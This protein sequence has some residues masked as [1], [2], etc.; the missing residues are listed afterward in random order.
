MSTSK[1]TLIYDQECPV[2]NNYVQMVRIR[3]SIGELELINARDG[4]EL[5]EEITAKGI[6]LDQGMV[7]IVDDVMYCNSDTIHALA[8]ISSPSGFLNKCNF[9]IF[10]NKRRSYV[11]YPVLRFF[12]RVLLMLLGKKKLNNLEHS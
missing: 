5:V 12:R 8:L 6:D 11:I 2:C 9:W 1:L 4:G 3:E 10:K 7:L